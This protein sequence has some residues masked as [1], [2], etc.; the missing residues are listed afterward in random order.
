MR[1]HPLDAVSLVSG[2]LFCG[3]GA[4]F[5]RGTDVTS[6]RWGVVWPV[7]LTVVGAVMLLSLVSARRDRHGGG[8]HGAH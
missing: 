6:W 2:L 1:R 3:L 7:A 4:I 8:D 5:L